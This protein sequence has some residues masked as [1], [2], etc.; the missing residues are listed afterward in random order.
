LRCKR[1]ERVKR[2]STKA[3]CWTT[4]FLCP[5]CAVIVHPLEYKNN[6]QQLWS[7]K[8][9]MFGR[10]KKAKNKHAGMRNPHYDPKEKS[11]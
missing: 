10:I 1:C 8:I 5:P 4:W 2:H 11:K 6:Q 9:D 3:K 7:K